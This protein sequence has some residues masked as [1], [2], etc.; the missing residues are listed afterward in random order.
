MGT[1]HLKRLRRRTDGADPAVAARARRWA[2]IALMCFLGCGLIGFGLM[3]AGIGVPAW[4]W[5]LR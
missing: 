2:L 3:A 5:T 1:K 4:A